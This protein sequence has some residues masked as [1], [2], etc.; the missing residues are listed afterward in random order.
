MA[1]VEDQDYDDDYEKV[2]DE[3]MEEACRVN[4][5]TDDDDYEGSLPGEPFV[6]PS[7]EDEEEADYIN[8]TS[9]QN[10]QVVDI[11]GDNESDDYENVAKEEQL[12]YIYD[13]TSFIYQNMGSEWPE[14]TEHSSLLR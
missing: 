5:E 12:V 10:V 6:R 11:F 4:Q 13:E 9:E 3:K 2:D 8:L 7:S 14:E 1:V